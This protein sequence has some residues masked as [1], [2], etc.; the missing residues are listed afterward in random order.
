MDTSLT[1]WSSPVSLSALQSGLATVSRRRAQQDATSSVQ[2]PGKTNRERREQRERGSDGG[3]RESPDSLEGGSQGRGRRAKD[4]RRRRRTQSLPRNTGHSE[5]NTER[6]VERDG[7]EREKG[8]ERRQDR[9]RRSKS[10]ERVKRKE[11]KREKDESKNTQTIDNQRLPE[12]K[13]QWEED[14]EEDVW[15][16]ERE[17]KWMRERERLKDKEREKASESDKE[18]ER[19]NEVDKE[20]LEWELNK[21][22]ERGIPDEL[23]IERQSENGA[24]T[25]FRNRLPYLGVRVLPSEIKPRSHQPLSGLSLEQ[26]VIDSEFNRTPFAFLTSAQPDYAESESGASVSECS[27]SAAS[28]SGLSAYLNES[29]TL[30]TT[31]RAPGPPLPGPWLKPSSQR[32]VREVE[33]GGGT[34][35]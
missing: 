5:E 12:P 4:E 17:Q 19:E 34:E 23:N 21:K 13:L 20:V 32:L 14:E 22:T 27:V 31:Q 18:W 33:K 35:T 10:E 3:D 8:N 15:E 1:T 25:S 11:R 29:L 28:I 30:K 16:R 9:S 2:K 6:R 24:E 7:R 26:P